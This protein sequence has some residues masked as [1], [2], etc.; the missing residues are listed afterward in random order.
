MIIY[1]LIKSYFIYYMDFIMLKKEKIIN[2]I[3]ILLFFI[4]IIFSYICIYNVLQY[5]ILTKDDLVFSYGREFLNP[6]HGRYLANYTTS[7]L[8]E[9]IPEYINIH[10]NDLQPTLMAFI[11][12]S[13]IIL[14]CLIIA[15]TAF[16]FSEK[17]F[18]FYN[19]AYI[20]TYVVVFLCLFNIFYFF[21]N[22]NPY[23]GIFENMVFFE[24]QMSIILYVILFSFI[25]YY[26]I[27]EKYI[28][29][30]WIYLFIIFISFCTGVSVDPVNVPSLFILILLGIT[31]LL[32]YYKKI[33]KQSLLKVSGVY[34][35]YFIG[36]LIYF[37]RPVHHYPDYNNLTFIEYFKNN[38][39][40]YCHN[41]FDIFIKQDSLIYIPI[42]ICI[43]LLLF[44][45]NYDKSKKKQII[46]LISISS[47]IYILFFFSIFVLGF[48]GNH[49]TF[50]FNLNKWISIYRVIG[51]F[52]LLLILGFLIDK[53]NYLDKKYSN[54]IKVILCIITLIIFRVNLIG[55]YLPNI[56]QTVERSKQIRKAAYIIE[57]LALNQKS[58]DIKIP[59]EYIE[60]NDIL[61]LDSKIYTGCGFYRY[62]QN[63]HPKVHKS[64]VTYNDNIDMSIFSDKE[65]TELKFQNLLTD[66]M[67]RHKKIIKNCY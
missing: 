51:L 46:L 59:K 10:P 32:Y 17:K 18:K 1:V 53:N 15:N 63:I 36:F 33:N 12:G 60:Y 61:Y 14:Q 19:P 67:Y 16:L 5:D 30:N 6:E 20:A 40:L 43:I 11:K 34:I 28:H 24:Y 58:E 26:F 39:V 31:L 64:S 55:E 38:I 49:N 29:S 4:L 42:L 47:F 27:N 21:N 50:Y 52:N 25:A 57:K 66:K 9:I 37:T 22:E 35:S 23:F 48:L 56:H 65:L 3:F 45:K 8:T 44:L 7:L 54:Y 13:L 41:Y 2:F 62:I